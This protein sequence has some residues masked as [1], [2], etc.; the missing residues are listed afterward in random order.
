MVEGNDIKKAHE[1]I[2]KKIS[3]MLPEKW[4]SLYLYASVVERAGSLQTGEM[5]FYYFPKGVL[6]KKPINVYEIPSRFNIDE[7][8]YSNF[9]ND[10]YNSIKNLRKVCIEEGEKPWSEI[11]ITIE[12]VKYKAIYGYEDLNTN[13]FNHDERHIIWRYKYL[14]VPY[15]SLNRVER[16]IINEY[17]RRPEEKTYTYEQSIYSKDSNK[18]LE[19]VKSIEKNLEFVT[20]D[21]IKEMEFKSTHV[22]KNQLLK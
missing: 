19:K 17:M 13:L 12:K 16:D 9:V 22:P 11:T 1:E 6:R 5:F 20:E 14:G 15:Q 10:L 4:D 3:L 2:Q 8:Q 18:K 7:K 21:K